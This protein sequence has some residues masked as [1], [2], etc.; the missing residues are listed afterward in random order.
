MRELNRALWHRLSPLL[1]RALDLDQPA[2][3]ELVATIRGQDP[4]LAA[5]LEQLLSEHQ[6]VLA[7]AF[8]ETPPLEGEP[9][10]EKIE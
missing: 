7:S 9:A 2:R 4:V 1:D 10:T 3:N 8:L 6:R 5:A